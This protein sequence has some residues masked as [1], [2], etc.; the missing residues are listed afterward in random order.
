MKVY[1]FY[2]TGEYAGEKEARLDPL[3][4]LFQGRDVFLLPAGATFEVPPIPAEGYARCWID[5]KW[6]IIEDHRGEIVYSKDDGSS[7]AVV[8]I[9]PIDEEYTAVKP[10]DNQEWDKNTG[11]W[12]DIVIPP[13]PYAEKKVIK[14]REIDAIRDSKVNEGVSFVFPNNVH[15]TIQ[16]RNVDDFRNIMGTAAAAI[17]LQ[18][19]EVTLPFRDQENRTYE[20]TPGEALALGLAVSSRVG[21]I[22]KTAWAHKDALTEENID[23]YDITIGWPE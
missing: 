4:S 7:V 12:I 14:H 21:E 15:G 13:L 22:Y 17:A 6:E 2:E 18:R 23:T 1:Y 8:V 9:G 3:E 10:K 11:Q 19:Q 5:G 16:T 20:M